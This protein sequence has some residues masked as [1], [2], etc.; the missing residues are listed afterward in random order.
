MIEHDAK[1]PRSLRHSLLAGLIAIA[2]LAFL[3]AVTDARRRR[4]D[5]ERLEEQIRVLQ[6]HAELMERQAKN[7]QLKPPATPAVLDGHEQSLS[8]SAGRN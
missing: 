6:T 5:V 1:P 7:P 2:F 8:P 3:A 4:S